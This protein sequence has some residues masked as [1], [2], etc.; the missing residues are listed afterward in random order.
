MTRFIPPSQ[1]ST[2]LIELARKQGY[3]FSKL[4]I[5]DP[6]ALAKPV[7]DLPGLSFIDL[8]ML[9][10][11]LFRALNTP[12]IPVGEQ[13]IFFI[14]LTHYDEKPTAIPACGAFHES[15]EHLRA[16][17]DGEITEILGFFV[18]L[19]TQFRSIS[20]NPMIIHC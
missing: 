10:L 1:E 11:L 7:G 3:C 13:N 15:P 18:H 17:F 16:V 5:Q 2:S 4:G 12:Q 20:R 14:Y 8:Y 9:Q 19:F 6:S